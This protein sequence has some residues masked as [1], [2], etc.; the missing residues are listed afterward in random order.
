MII[1]NRT[2]PELEGPVEEPQAVAE[3]QGRREEENALAVSRDGRVAVQAAALV[4]LFA[5]S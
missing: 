1:I 3:P 4:C 5:H 2:G